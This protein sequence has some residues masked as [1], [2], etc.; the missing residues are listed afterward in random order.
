MNNK[1]MNDEK[2][3]VTEE[4]MDDM[5]FKKDILVDI[6]VD[7]LGGG[8]K[9]PLVVSLGH[10]RYEVRRFSNLEHRIIQL[11][12][13]ELESLENLLDTIDLENPIKQE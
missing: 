6:L 11:L 13:K 7:I 8:N 5:I 1:K 10:N 4:F 3:R 12:E 9:E 2:V